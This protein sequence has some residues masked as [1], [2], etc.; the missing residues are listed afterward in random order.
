MN[1]AD[2]SKI[3]IFQANRKFSPEEKETIISKLQN[4]M[5]DWNARTVQLY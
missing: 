1:L 5:L 3:W 2:N 4:F